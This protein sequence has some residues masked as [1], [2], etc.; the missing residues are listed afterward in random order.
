MASQWVPATRPLFRAALASRPSNGHVAFI[1]Q[2]RKLVFEFC[3]KWPSS[4]NTRT[5][6]ER[7]LEE[8]ARANPHVEIVVKQRNQREPIARGFYLNNRDKVVPLNGLEVTGIQQKVQL[9]LDASGAKIKPL[10]R[11]T[12]ESS[13]EAARGIWSGLHAEPYKI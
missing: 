9:L 8:L 2:I 3:E 10:K 7:H 6:I 12:V 13:T 4:H 1:P 11:R 5:Y